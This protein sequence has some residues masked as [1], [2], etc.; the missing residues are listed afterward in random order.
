MALCTRDWLQPL[1]R[2]GL[3]VSRVAFGAGPVSN[4]LTESELN[5]TELQFRTI[6]RALR[7]GINW[8]DTAA[9]YAEGKSEAIL[10]RVLE[11]LDPQR[12]AC[13]AT[14]VRIGPEETGEIRDAV[15]RS[16]EGSLKRLRVSQV[17][18]LQ[19]HNSVTDERGDQPTS[20]CM[21]DVLGSRGVAETFRELRE[22]GVIQSCGLTGIG[23][24]R[25]LKELLDSGAF[26]TIQTPCHLL[27]PSA[28][29]DV[30]RNF[31][32]TD[33]ERLL[34]HAASRQCGTFA[35]RVLAGG[36][37]A[38]HPPSPHTHRTKFFPLDLYQR[39]CSRAKRVEERIASFG[40]FF[41]RPLREIALH[42]LFSCRVVTS[43]IIGFS[44]PEQ[45]DEAV[46]LAQTPCMSQEE[47]SLLES[48]SLAV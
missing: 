25:L 21:E 40:E 45:V 42:Y 44:T 35:I 16:V 28:T 15:L 19:L 24:P 30:P 29:R 33:S 26:E 14:K 7:Q 48:E 18:L 34:Q 22:Q 9:T 41:Q 32:D 39:D 36:A 6:E 10:G 47:I 20:L 3:L 13:L 37:L 1:G 11:Q 4:L 2:T 43:A 38:G 46:R 5:P 27:N 8:F 17:T 23:E 12:S 31:E